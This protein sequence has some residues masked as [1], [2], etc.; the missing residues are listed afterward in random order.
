VSEPWDRPQNLPQ[1]L[2]HPVHHEPRYS[3]PQRPAES[4]WRRS[5]G[6]Y[7][8]YPDEGEHE[9]S[10]RFLPGF[11]DD[12]QP[13]DDPPARRRR[14][15]KGRRP[16]KPPKRRRRFRWLAPLVALLV[17]LVPLGVGGGYAYSF[18]MSKYHP[19]DYSGPGTGHVVVQVMS[20]DTPTSLG[21]RLQHAGVI[22]SARALVLA[23]EHSQNTSI[24]V[25]GF[26]G[27][28]EHMQA[29]L[30]YAALLDVKNLVQITVTIPEGW[31]VSQVQN[32]LGQK[33]G[34]PASAYASVLKDPAQLHLPAY[35]AGDPE[36]YL[37]PA[38]Y[39]V[40]PHET[41]LGV[42]A[43]MV[44]RFDQ[45][46]A[47]VNL[48]A[49]AKQVHLTPAQV[50]TMAS[51]VQAEG[52]RL[53]DYRNIAEVINNRLAQHMPLQ[54]DST[55]L[56]GLGKFGII[57]SNA[58]LN[59]PSPYNTYRHKGLPPGPIDSPG[60]AAIQAVLHPATGNYLYFVTVDPK[61]GLTR[62][63]ASEAQF[64]QFRAELEHNMSQG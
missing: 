59:S 64:E 44:Q 51:L 53:T 57:A 41:A 50:I 7:D 39:A 28:R 30:A 40:Q 37:F 27:M 6:S 61:T 21:P 62:F 3:D 60:D 11:G 2:P 38:T 19:P 33:S 54:L 13:E 9:P 46:A 36:G 1:N 17:V 4:P 31:R 63:T 18:Y 29:S 43:G 24:L 15:K 56:F 34:T 26:Y 10:G 35:A 8:Q 5:Q 12:T 20:G 22:A 58:D 25:P 14:G 16:P 48:V 23:A 52:G 32:W 55:V 42:L 49:A 47:N 45:E